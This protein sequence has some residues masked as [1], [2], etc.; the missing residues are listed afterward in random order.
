M[1]L[2]CSYEVYHLKSTFPKFESSMI[3]LTILEAFKVMPFSPQKW[4]SNCAAKVPF[5]Q[6]TADVTFVTL[7]RIQYG[8]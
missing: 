2:Y 7:Y 6:K 8:E 5:D 1:K 4:Y 3:K